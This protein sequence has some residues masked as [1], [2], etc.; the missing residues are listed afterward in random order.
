MSQSTSI[1]D[2]PKDNLRNADEA[3][4]VQSIINDNVE[5]MNN[6]GLMD[7]QPQQA[8][9]VVTQRETR[10]RL[11]VLQVMQRRIRTTRQCWPVMQRGS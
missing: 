5:E 3:R 8:V 10:L 1:R 11:V 4:I 9:L 6:P 7:Q 2:L